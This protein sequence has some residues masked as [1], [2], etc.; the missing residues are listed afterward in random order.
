MGDEQ[1]PLIR[2][3]GTAKL[4]GMHVASLT[5]KLS[6]EGFKASGSAGDFVKLGPLG[7]SGI[8]GTVRA[9]LDAKTQFL[10]MSGKLSAGKLG[11]REFDLDLKR[12]RAYFSSPAS[13]AYPFDVKA[14]VKIDPRNP[15][16]QLKN[17]PFSPLNGV[18]DAA[19]VARCGAGFLYAVKDG[20]VYL[21]KGGKKVAEFADKL[22]QKNEATKL[23]SGAVKLVGG[24]T[25]KAASEGAKLVRADKAAKAAKAGVK[26]AAKRTKQAAQAAK[27]AA[28]VAKNVATNVGKEAGQRFTNVMKSVGAAIGGLF[29]G[30][31]KSSGPPRPPNAADCKTDQFWNHVTKQCVTRGYQY[32]IH[33]RHGSNNPKCLEVIGGVVH[34]GQHA[35]IEKCTGGWWQQWQLQRNG[36]MK[37]PVHH[38]CL[39]A[40]NMKVGEEVRT[41]SCTN[42]SNQKWRIDGQGRLRTANGLCAVPNKRKWLSLARCKNL[43][44]VA[45]EWTRLTLFEDY[46]RKYQLAKEYLVRVQVNNEKTCLNV[47]STLV[48]C[49]HA[50]KYDHP[51]RRF[52]VGFVDAH[53]LALIN[54]ANKACL[55][56]NYNDRRQTRAY[57]RPCDYQRHNLWTVH[58]VDGRGRVNFKRRDMK[59]ILKGRF[60]LRNNA[61]NRCLTSHFGATT[62]GQLWGV[63]SCNPN[64][65]P[66][67]VLRL[68]TVGSRPQAT[69][70]SRVALTA[71]ALRSGHCIQGTGKKIAVPARARPCKMPK[72][73]KKRTRMGQ[74]DINW[75]TRHA[76]ARFW[77][78]NTIHKIEFQ[79]E[80]SFVIRS[81]QNDKCLDVHHGSKK[82]GTQIVSY[83]CGNS[84]N[85]EQKNQQWYVYG[86]FAKA[87]AG[88]AWFGIR[89]RNS[90]LCIQR[91]SDGRLIQ[92]RCN[93]KDA[94]QQFILRN[95]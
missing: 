74:V 90:G 55:G 30:G 86:D 94:A 45:R 39:D 1:G 13:C 17:L 44:G 20:V 63:K 88:Q 68:R 58:P 52:T 71:I 93:S 10:T 48:E 40:K 6:K 27:A 8:R 66:T 34:N 16:L 79:S 80:S 49:V 78:L 85:R 37:T 25:I 31:K 67:Q 5:G 76:R 43:P 28:N 77:T 41:W 70:S 92:V 91:A 32:V 4:L 2:I 50:K 59:N 57:L 35:R 61:S 38:R 54:A 9:Q 87:M 3:S 46:Q 24:K 60:V 15:K 84:A 83:H 12:T 82:P 62:N 42:R 53:R 47:N 11:G 18:P 7:R 75:Q 19:T 56:S 23:A 14:N 73:K 95:P 26:E 72:I 64:V 51:H 29:G 21:F 81:R 36:W 89:S 22:M 65:H 69:G 33:T